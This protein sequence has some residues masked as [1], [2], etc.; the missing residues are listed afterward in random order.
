[1]P[2]VNDND[3]SLSWTR[4]SLTKH[5]LENWK[6]VSAF[7]FNLISSFQIISAGEKQ[8]TY[9][10]L[11]TLTQIQF[12]WKEKEQPFNY[13]DEISV[14]L[15]QYETKFSLAGPYLFFEQ[16]PF[17]DVGYF[18]QSI[19]IPNL[20][21]HIQT[22]EKIL[23]GN[24]RCCDRNEKWYNTSYSEFQLAHD[25]FNSNAQHGLFDKNSFWK[26]DV[27]L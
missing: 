20:R 3:F 1:M 21:I 27:D 5:G 26:N 18:I 17:P 4:I 7:F 12:D 24:L 14:N 10:R 13:V 9:E 15:Q 16:N 11:K 19:R 6:N 8:Q 22:K 25:E 2:I 23:P